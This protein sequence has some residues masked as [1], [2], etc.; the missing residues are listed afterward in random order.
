M[1][2]IEKRIAKIDEHIKD[3]DKPDNWDELC[4]KF[5]EFFQYENAYEWIKKDRRH[6]KFYK[7]ES[8]HDLQVA[9]DILL[10]L[11]KDFSV[12]TD[13]NSYKVFIEGKYIKKWSEDNN[14]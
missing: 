4:D 7:A 14:E 3:E 13:V 2:K 12:E 11:G 1:D 6:S 5:Y 9:I 8:E 10:S